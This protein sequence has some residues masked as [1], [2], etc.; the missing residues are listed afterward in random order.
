MFREGIQAC[1][2]HGTGWPAKS[3]KEHTRNHVCQLKSVEEVG[4]L[5]EHHYHKEEFAAVAYLRPD[6]LYNEAFP[7]ELIPHLKVLCS[8]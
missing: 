5:W 6:V 4:Q 8:C 3:E 2:K 1:L 7:V